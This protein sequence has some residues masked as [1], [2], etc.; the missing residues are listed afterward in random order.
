MIW[1]LLHKMVIWLL[2]HKMVICLLLHKMGCYQ[3][4]KFLSLVLQLGK[5]YHL[6]MIWQVFSCKKKRGEKMLKIDNT[7]RTWHWW[8]KASK[9]SRKSHEWKIEVDKNQKIEFLPHQLLKFCAQKT[10]HYSRQESK[11]RCFNS[12]VVTMVK[13]LSV[14]F[15]VK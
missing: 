9:H 7:P 3:N 5:R 11:C 4:T 14:L 8:P 2:L 10:I 1:L 6:L 13:H 12:S 15:T